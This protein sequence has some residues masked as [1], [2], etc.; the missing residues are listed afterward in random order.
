M[1]IS[2]FWTNFLDTSTV[3]NGGSM[4]ENCIEAV[5]HQRCRRNRDLRG[6]A[7]R[8]PLLGFSFRQ[9]V[10][11][12]RAWSSSGPAWCF[13]A[14]GKE[15]QL[16][17]L[18]GLNSLW[19]FK[20]IKL[21]HLFAPC[22]RSNRG[23]EFFYHSHF[24]LNNNWRQ[25]NEDVGFGGGGE[26]LPGIYLQ[27]HRKFS[28]FISCGQQH[29]SLTR[30]VALFPIFQRRK[31]RN[32]GIFPG[33]SLERQRLNS[34]LCP[35]TRSQER[36]AV[37]GLRPRT[38]IG[39]LGAWDWRWRKMRKGGRTWRLC[40]ALAFKQRHLISKCGFN[41]GWQMGLIYSSEGPWTIPNC[42]HLQA[43]VSASHCWTSATLSTG[44]GVWGRILLRSS[45]APVLCD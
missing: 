18:R 28:H 39:A 11:P 29:S 22:R 13:R 24:L 34:V 31:L 10:G 33:W 14:L 37:L 12:S 25:D 41:P 9:L 17:L 7:G 45:P 19:L 40:L 42:R 35:W 43:R 8:S 15:S 36:R 5:C 38:L 1:P 2:K 26:T 30:L 44:Q 4:G 21:Y 23:C 27:S 6:E 16:F 32:E 3:M 20:H